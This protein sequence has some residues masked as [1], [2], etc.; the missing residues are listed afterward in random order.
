MFRWSLKPKRPTP[1]V[2]GR[3][4]RW[5]V[6]PTPV[7]TNELVP[8][9]SVARETAY[10]KLLSR[11]LSES[12]GNAGSK[13]ASGAF[14]G[15]TGHHAERGWPAHWHFVDEHISHRHSLQCAVEDSHGSEVGYAAGHWTGFH[16]RHAER[17]RWVNSVASLSDEILTTL[18]AASVDSPAQGSTLH[19][20][21]AHRTSGRLR[22]KGALRPR[23]PRLGC[24]TGRHNP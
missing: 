7:Q 9:R 8:P 16:L 24:T 4:T 10:A 2:R 11:V 1:K 14:L 20:A 5:L 19:A 18:A 21:K 15:T 13:V 23:V 6:K 17:Q 3:G 12:C 22:R